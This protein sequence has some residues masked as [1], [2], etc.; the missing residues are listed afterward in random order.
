MTNILT[1]RWILS[2]SSTVGD[3][4]L[5]SSQYLPQWW[6]LCNCL[7]NILTVWDIGNSC[8]VESAK[9]GDSQENIS[10]HISVFTMRGIKKIAHLNQAQ[11]TSVGFPL[12][13][14]L[15]YL[16]TKLDNTFWASNFKW[17]KI[18]SSL[19]KMWW[20]HYMYS[21]MTQRRLVCH[22]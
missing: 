11:G 22:K 7:A 12:V 10:C 5:V 13:C 16:W 8:I 15:C 20:S 18:D 6:I 19:P 2:I 4:V 14:F 17:S 9:A 21:S 3:I 1:H